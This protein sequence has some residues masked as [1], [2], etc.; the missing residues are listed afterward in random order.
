M[1]SVKAVRPDGT[2][3]LDNPQA[4]DEDGS[5]FLRALADYIVSMEYGEGSLTYVVVL[6]SG[7][8]VT[9]I[10]DGTEVVTEGDM[11][12]WNQITQTWMP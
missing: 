3:W 5:T 1:M 4:S 6:S 12:G 2:V 10:T 7:S 11:V 9:V 8:T